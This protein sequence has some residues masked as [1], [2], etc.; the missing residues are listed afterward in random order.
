MAARTVLEWLSFF[1]SVPDSH[2]G[3]FLDFDEG[4][5]RNNCLGAAAEIS[6]EKRPYSV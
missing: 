2:S 3:Q 1:V 4:D 5:D 6:C